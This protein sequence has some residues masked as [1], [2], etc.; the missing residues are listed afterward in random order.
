MILLSWNC[1]ELGHLRKV[2]DLHQMVKE[3][4]PTFVFLMENICSKQY[5]DNIRKR[6]G[7]DNFFAVDP[8]GRSGGLA[9]LWNSVTNLE[10]Y[11]YSR[12][13]INVVVK[14]GDNNPLWKLTG[15]YGHPD[16]GRRAESWE[17]LKF[18]KTCHPVPWLCAGDFSEIVEQAE[19]EGSN[20]RKES[21]MTGFREALEFCRLGDL[22]FSGSMFT[23]SNR[24][25][26][27]TFTKE[28]LD[29]AMAN[30]EWCTIFPSFSVLIM[31]ARSSNHSPILV[32]FFARNIERQGQGSFSSGFKFEASWANDVE[33]GDVISS[34]WNNDINDV[35][36]SDG[37]Q[38]RLSA[39]Q[40][41]L[42]TWSRQKY[43][44]VEDNIK[45]KSVQ[46][47]A[48]QR[49]ESPALATQIKTLQREIDELLEFEELKWKQRAKQHWLKHG[50]RNTAFFHSWVQHRRKINHI[51]SIAD[52]QGRIWRKNMDITRV[53]LSYYE[54]LFTTQSAGN[55]EEY[56][57]FVDNRVINDM[58]NWL[59][60]SFLEEEVQKA[61]FQMHP[62]KSPGPDG[63][64][65]VF[66]Q[67]NWST[68]GRDVCKAV[69]FYLNGGQLDE[70][71]NTTNIVLIPKVNSPSK[72]A[73][74]RPIS[75]CNVLY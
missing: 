72:L 6:L 10:V 37:I 73:D 4:R 25:T 56:I 5:M 33:C 71:L 19:N 74:Y 31:A 36:P 29:R 62:L 28:R 47:A 41:A 66:Y 15:F 63:Y 48:L 54:K 27:G 67:K 7:F 22:G 57:N 39:C 50:D 53:F 34:A 8:V 45:R 64:P 43:G 55:V 49:N 58:N 46:L 32:S 65:A 70:G 61:L 42:L 20:I 51:R 60:H 59:L 17:L 30:P 14:D 21:Q 23:W 26:D 13:H 2:R 1:R 18:L 38:M 35:V 68:V 9:L 3:R 52:E 24:R 16:C 11:N 44:K 69:L 75:L 40:R 12:R